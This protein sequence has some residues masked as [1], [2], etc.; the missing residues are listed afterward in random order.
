MT[1]IVYRDGVMASDTSAWDDR[2]VH[3]WSRKII[4]GA[5]GSLYGT[6][7]QCSEGQA[8]LRWVDEGCVGEQPMPRE[9]VNEDDSFGILRVREPGLI[10]LLVKPYGWE[11]FK[12]PYY[13]V[14]GGSAVS[15]G[16]LYA[17]ADAETAV[18]AAIEHSTVARGDVQ[19]IRHEL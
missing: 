7:G 13:A 9:V 16:T 8:F 6:F 3:R 19:S 18:R 11:V 5:D 14:G 15:W 4:R 1:V 10:G 17:G 12:A 2:S